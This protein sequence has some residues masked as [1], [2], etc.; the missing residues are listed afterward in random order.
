MFFLSLGC[1]LGMWPEGCIAEPF[2]L[3]FST[4][5]LEG[6]LQGPPSVA[7]LH[8]SSVVKAIKRPSTYYTC[9]L[10]GYFC[11]N[12]NWSILRA[13]SSIVCEILNPCNNQVHISWSVYPPSGSVYSKEAEKVFFFFN[14]DKIEFLFEE[15]TSCGGWKGLVVWSGWILLICCSSLN[16]IR[17]GSLEYQDL[18]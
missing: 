11:L 7:C 1:S 3:R 10:C 5:G 6:F 13:S 15:T 14:T 8:S 17:V 12:S 2:W 18:G 9:I 4:P 16:P